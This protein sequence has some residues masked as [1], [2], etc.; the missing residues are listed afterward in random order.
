MKVVSRDTGLIVGWAHC[1]HFGAGDPKSSAL[2]Q[3][4]SSHSQKAVHNRITCMGYSKGNQKFS[5]RVLYFK[6]FFFSFLFYLELRKE[7]SNGF[8][9]LA[10]LFRDHCRSL[11]CLNGAVTLVMCTCFP[12]VVQSPQSLISNKYIHLHLHLCV[13]S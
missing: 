8:L 10:A 6:C 4:D 13:T 5:Y 1:T 9:L 2:T 7:T 11:S 3:N 12:R